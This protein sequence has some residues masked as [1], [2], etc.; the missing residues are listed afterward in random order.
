[1]TL[2]LRERKESLREYAR[3][4]MPRESGRN[5]AVREHFL[6][7]EQRQLAM[8]VQEKAFLVLAHTLSLTQTYLA[9]PRL[10]FRRILIYSA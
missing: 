7:C 2:L 5:R 1:M 3:E 8:C 10:L 6:L 4:T 9:Y